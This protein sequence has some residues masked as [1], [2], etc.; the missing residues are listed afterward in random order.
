MKFSDNEHSVF[1]FNLNPL[2][3]KSERN[4][5]SSRKEMTEGNEAKSTNQ[6]DIKQWRIKVKLW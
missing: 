1:K 6:F 4:L 5:F 3:T 2:C